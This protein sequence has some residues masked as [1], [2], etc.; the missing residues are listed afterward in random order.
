[1]GSLYFP[2]CSCEYRR[3]SQKAVILRIPDTTFLSF[4]NNIL[5]RWFLF[6]FYC[7]PLLLL[8]FTTLILARS[9][10]GRRSGLKGRFPFPFGVYSYQR[11]FTGILSTFIMS[12]KN[13]KGTD[14]KAPTSAATNLI[15]K[16]PML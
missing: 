3:L 14:G 16:L 6:T 13:I 15:G 10:P 1:M 12:A 11:R 4:K 8:H 9:W 7:F 2:H 5:S